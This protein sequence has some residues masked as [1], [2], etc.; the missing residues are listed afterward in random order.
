MISSP[1]LAGCGLSYPLGTLQTRFEMPA[2]EKASLISAVHR[3][4]SGQFIRV[5]SL[6]D[7][8]NNGIAGLWAVTFVSDG[9]PPNP[10]PAGMITDFGTVQWHP[11]GTEIMVS[12]GRPPSTGDVCMGA[13]SQ[14]GPHTYK[15]KHV[16]LAWVSSD[17]PP[18]MGGPV[19]PAQFLGPA[20]ISEVVTLSKSHDTYQGTFAID[21][22]NADQKAVLVHV[23]GTIT[24][25]RITPD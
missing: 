2:G 20:I 6:N 10:V 17:T 1:A 14:T 19:S 9:I 21:Q 12:G 13:W 7:S 18:T 25:T 11:D 15:L 22:Y 5:A 24:G 3:P 23:S 4:G 16:A 8:P